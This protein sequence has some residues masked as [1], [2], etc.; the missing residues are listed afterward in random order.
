MHGHCRPVPEREIPDNINVR[1][2]YPV[3]EAVQR[4]GSSW[5]DHRVEC[6]T[7]NTQ[8]VAALNTGR[9]AN[10]VSMS[11]LRD[12]FWQSV[13]FNCRLVAIYLPGKDNII[14]DALSRMSVANDIPVFLC[15]RS[16]GSVQR[17]RP[18]SRRVEIAGMGTGYLENQNIAVET[19]H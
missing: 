8:V 3:L 12:I 5:R 15:C 19:V 6:V 18:E 17:A 16:E 9:S 4:W 10:A 7:D 14:A 13:I 11:L 1:E 2:L